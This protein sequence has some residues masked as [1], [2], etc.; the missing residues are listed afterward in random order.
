V[1]EAAWHSYKM[2]S[3]M[4]G[5]GSTLVQGEF[6]YYGGKLI[7]FDP[8]DEILLMKVIEAI[9]HADDDLLLWWQIGYP[10]EEALFTW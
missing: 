4:H 1:E 5:L 9:V 10:K 7:T 8:S 3:W 2:K 6:Q